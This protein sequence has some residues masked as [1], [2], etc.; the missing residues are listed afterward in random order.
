MVVDLYTLSIPG[1]TNQYAQINEFFADFAV[2][3]RLVAFLDYEH[4]EYADENMSWLENREDIYIGLPRLLEA[5][6]ELNRLDDAETLLKRFK[7]VINEISVS[8]EFF[9]R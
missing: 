1:L 5:Y 2:G 9:K 6:V 4:L 8:K 3:N 7:P